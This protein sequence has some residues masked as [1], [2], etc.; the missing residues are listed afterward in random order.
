MTNKTSTI[1]QLGLFSTPSAPIVAKEFSWTKQSFFALDIETNGLNPAT[2]RI[3]EI[4]LVPFNM[5]CDSH[6]NQLISIP[7]PLPLEIQKITGIN[8]NMLKDKPSFIEVADRILGSIKN[9]DFIV[10]YNVAFDKPFLES[11]LARINKALPNIPWV[12]PFVFICEIDRYK[13]GKKLIDAAKRWGVSLEDAHRAHNDALAAGELLLKLSNTI[14]IDD[15]KD[16][17]EKQSI[18]FWKNAH[19]RHEMQQ[20]QEWSINR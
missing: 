17:V 12:D 14:A 4:A 2:D 19:N 20:K 8:D 16:L 11:E 10:A 18:L 5:S 13:K 9:A 3:I 1:S 15:L 7:T 6:I